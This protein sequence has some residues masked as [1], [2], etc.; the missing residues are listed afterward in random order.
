[1][2]KLSGGQ[3]VEGEKEDQGPFGDVAWLCVAQHRQAT[4]NFQIRG[5]IQ[6]QERNT[7][8]K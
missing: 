5:D 1:M 6:G 3:M 2:I 8:N 4:A 7:S